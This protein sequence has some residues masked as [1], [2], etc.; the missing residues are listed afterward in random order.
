MCNFDI[1]WG[2]NY[3]RIELNSQC[4]D[5]LSL[6]LHKGTENYIY[7]FLYLAAPPAQFLSENSLFTIG[8]NPLFSLYQSAIH[9]LTTDY[10]VFF[11]FPALFNSIVVIKLFKRYSSNA[12]FTLLVFYSVGT[13]V[14]YIAAIKQSI[15][16]AILMLALP[17]AIGRK[18][19][20][21]Y[22]LVYIAMQHSFPL[23][24]QH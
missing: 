2:K 15:A 20:K 9:A 18:H 3:S 10:H 4:G 12:A 23:Y 7:D 6:L 17:Y 13:Y 8:K 11:L 19:V 14:M 22:I 21:F 24:L 1:Y 16:V 5:F